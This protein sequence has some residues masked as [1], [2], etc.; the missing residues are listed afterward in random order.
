MP[1]R[2]R[3]LLTFTLIITLTVLLLG[4][5]LTW[6]TYN[7]LKEEKEA[8][9]LI[10]ARLLATTASVVE[11]FPR[12]MEDTIGNQM[13]VE[14]TLVAH[15]V[16]VAEEAGLSENE[17][18]I[19]LQKIVAET[20]LSEVWVS[21]A[22][23]HAYLRNLTDIDFTFSPDPELQ[24][25]ASDF[26][27]L[28]TGEKS[29]VIQ[30]AQ[31]REV[32]DESFKYVGVGGVDGPRI[33]QVGYN[34]TWLGEM[35]E[36]V[37]VQWLVK[38]LVDSGNIDAIRIAD[39]QNETLILSASPEFDTL[40]LSDLDH[41]SL[42]AALENGSEQT[43][44][45]NNVLKVIVPIY[46]QIET[47]EVEILGT[48]IA[49]SSIDN[50]QAALNRELVFAMSGAFIAWGLGFLAIYIF[51]NSVT[52]PILQ[53]SKA[54]S[55]LQTGDYQSGTLENVRQRSDELGTLGEVFAQ[56][57]KTVA[58]RDKRLELLKV[59]IPM[60]VR[61][62]AEKDFDRLL[63]MMVI[64][65]QR[66]TNADGGTLYLREGDHLRFVVIRNN[67]L[68]IAMGGRTGNA[69]SFAPLALYDKASNPNL[70]NVAAYVVHKQERVHLE[71]AYDADGFDFSGT[72]RF[73]QSTGYRSKSFL[74]FPLEGDEGEVI[75][76]LQL[77]NAIDPD[78]QAVI[79]FASDEVVDSLSL[80]T[81]AAL[82]GYIRAESLRQEIDKLRI[83]ID[84]KKQDEQVDEITDTLYF[85][86]LHA[87]AREVRAQKNHK[88]E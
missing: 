6:N 33:V 76:V 67:T 11:E 55:K 65:A 72:E 66:I 25:Q 8:D 16:A 32:D 80:L 64:E 60:G 30:D 75:G 44:I 28:L 39:S 52:K 10:L 77:I 14:A 9:A 47:D 83:K 7:T 56:M 1:L 13:V 59:I 43:Y 4:S 5:L 51:G 74:T 38:N 68:G 46:S 81:S 35:R 73:D 3:M 23:G 17:I 87:K 29:V 31:T 15:L 19:L 48:A 22:A 50:L 53:I 58:Q 20:E 84:Q 62:S 34:A 79:P 63:E 41:D 71:D 36:R 42:E 12:A 2:T 86:R 37:G 69:I 27:A 61:L 88:K 18:N 54:A 70:A 85:K 21:D 49:Y 40:S 24:P 78:T 57:A 45:E 82:A 26:W